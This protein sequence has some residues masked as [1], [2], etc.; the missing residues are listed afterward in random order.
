M[1]HHSLG[2]ISYSNYGLR[3]LSL[4]KRCGM[5]Q[6]FL[7]CAASPLIAVEKINITHFMYLLKLTRMLGAQPPGRLRTL[8]F[9]MKLIVAGFSGGD[10]CDI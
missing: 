2:Q 5:K 7:A 6:K 4:F 8:L 1:E 9:L 3:F 10:P